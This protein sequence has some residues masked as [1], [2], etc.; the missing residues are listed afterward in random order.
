MA[1]YQKK[2]LARNKKW[3]PQA[4]TVG[5]PV[6]TEEVAKKLAEL[7]SISKG[8]VETVLDTLGGVM[9]D[10]MNSG[11]TVKLRG[12]GTY[13]YTINAEGNGVDNP[14]D[15]SARLIKNTR[16]RFIPEVRRSAS[17]TVTSRSLI[18]EFLSWEELPSSMEGSA[19]T[20]GG[21]GEGGGEESGE[22]PDPIG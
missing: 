21:S 13:Y 9:A 1:F 17:N 8:D 5:K 15:V 6:T 11:R 10:Y 3:Y 12:L 20:P 7:T 16:V 2:Q 22:S 4:I 19:T 18:N 14:D